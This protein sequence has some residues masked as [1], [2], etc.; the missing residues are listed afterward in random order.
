M[1]GD[2]GLGFLGIVGVDWFVIVFV[3]GEG[4]YFMDCGFV[5]D[6]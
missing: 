6:D 1:I 5:I 4:D 3:K 2:C